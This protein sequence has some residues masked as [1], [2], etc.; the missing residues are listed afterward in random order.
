MFGCSNLGKVLN[1]FFVAIFDDYVKA[2]R[3]N[4]SYRVY[5]NGGRCKE[6]SGRDEL[7]PQ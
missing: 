3:K 1:A 6:R 4:A 2:F 5:L 7:K